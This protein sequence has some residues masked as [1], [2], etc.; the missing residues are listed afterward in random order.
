MTLR[1]SAAM[2]VSIANCDTLSASNVPDP[3][4][5]HLG[6][7]PRCGACMDTIF[8]HERVVALLS[9]EGSTSNGKRTRPFPFPQ[10]GY[11]NTLVDGY[12]LCR[13][14]ACGICA[15][16]P[17]CVP[18]HHDYYGWS[19]KGGSS[20][21]RIM[22][23]C[24]LPRLQSLPPEL[25]ELIRQLSPHALFWRAIS[26]ISLASNVTIPPQP[27]LVF[28]LKD[29]E[30]WKRGESVVRITEQTGRC[31]PMTRLTVDSEGIQK[32]DRLPATPK[33]RRGE[34]VSRYA[35]IVERA[36]ALSSVQAHLKDNLLRL[37]LPSSLPA[38]RTWDT[39]APPILDNCRLCSIHVHDS[40]ESC[41][42]PAYHRLSNRCQKGAVWIYWPIA[43][44]D[45]VVAL[46]IRGE[47]DI[48]IRTRLIGNVVVGSRFR[49]AEAGL[50]LGGTGK[51]TLLYGEPRE[52]ENIP[53]IGGCCSAHAPFTARIQSIPRPE[54]DCRM[55]FSAAPIG[56]VSSAPVWYDEQN[57]FCRG[58]LFEYENGELRAVGQCRLHV[59]PSKKYVRP[60]RLC[61]RTNIR[62]GHKVQ[63]TRVVFESGESA[64]SHYDYSADDGW[65]CKALRGTLMFWFSNRCSLLCV[66]Q[67]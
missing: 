48:L 23:I 67:T 58:I 11:P 4:P 54:K 66:E 8:R 53:L 5:G 61:F 52:G 42:L 26:T 45:S 20:L 39:P 34:T 10:L 1:D 9:N 47:F 32:I 25:V 62:V 30:T 33:Y 64:H 28:P 36:E 38:L 31:R 7:V 46:S 35:Y 44:Q 51:C 17:E 13:H 50:W 16:S 12:R 27:L 6:L 49:G 57:G 21:L 15:R 43:R 65:Q 19:V 63:G 14:P 60:S 41:A 59:D 56:M 40:D 29:I 24:G 37:M 55:H 18:I 3:G 22:H 2:Q